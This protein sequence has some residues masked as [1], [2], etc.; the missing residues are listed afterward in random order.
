MPNTDRPVE[1]LIHEL[2][3][4]LGAEE[5]IGA[6]LPDALTKIV[7]DFVARIRKRKID[8]EGLVIVAE[9]NVD[10]IRKRVRT[11]LKDL[12]D[13][14]PHINTKYYPDASGNN[15]SSTECQD[16]GAEL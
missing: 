11:E 16:C 10:T 5:K 14:C 4:T 8:L 6:K 1:V 3:T 7:G 9:Q 15:D 13:Q 12:Q 2:R